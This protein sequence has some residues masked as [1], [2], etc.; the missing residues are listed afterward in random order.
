MDDARHRV[1]MELVVMR[2]QPRDAGAHDARMMHA[3][4]AQARTIVLG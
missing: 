2:L 3:Q 4:N 1:V